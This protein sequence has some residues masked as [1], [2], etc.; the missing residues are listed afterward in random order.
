MVV[1][2]KAAPIP[3][4]RLSKLLHEYNGALNLILRFERLYPLALLNSL[5]SP[6]KLEESALLN[7]TEVEA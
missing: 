3:G 4:N 7:K 1:N 5:V 2:E 6:P